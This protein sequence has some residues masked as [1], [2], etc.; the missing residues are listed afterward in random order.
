MGG[1]TV[2]CRA[3]GHVPSPRFLEA[4]VKSLIIT[5]GAPQIY[6]LRLL[7]PPDFKIASPKF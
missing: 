7:S 6:N 3:R 4:N 1:S 5:I 2:D